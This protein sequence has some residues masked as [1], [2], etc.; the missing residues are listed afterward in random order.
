MYCD[1]V[2]NSQIGGL[3][4]REIIVVVESLMITS[5][6][7]VHLL[8]LSLTIATITITIMESADL[9]VAQQLHDSDSDSGDSKG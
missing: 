2:P 6:A 1:Q 9:H 5:F 8:R 7:E 4:S 3:T